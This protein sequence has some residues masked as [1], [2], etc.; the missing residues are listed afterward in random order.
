[1]HSSF[2]TLQR[3]IGCGLLALGMVAGAG[4]AQ[5][6]DFPSRSVRLVIPGPA[7]GATDTMARLLANGLSEKWGQSVVVE[8]K[9]GGTGLVSLR[10]TMGA[11]PDGHVLSM[12]IS[13]FMP[14]N[15]LTHGSQYEALTASTPIAFLSEYPLFL[16]TKAERPYSNWKELDAYAKQHSNRASYGVSGVAGTPHLLGERIKQRTGIDLQPVPYKGDAPMLTAVI[17]DQVDFA[18]PIAA[19]AMPMVKAGRVKPLAVTSAERAAFAPDVPTLRE[20]GLEL[21]S[22]P[23]AMIAG[24]AGMKADL[25]ARIN[26][27]VHDVIAS[28]AM[29]DYY[30]ANGVVSKKMTP[31]ELAAYVTSENDVA[32]KIIREANIEVK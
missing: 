24:P 13:G 18:M 28:K 26:Q 6:Q 21:V 29:R 30:E 17:G 3:A 7:G 10:E 9:P 19:S 4:M 20:Q 27:D 5:A 22:A 32:L 8:N 11:D 31:Q 25:V 12:M 2:K 15:A 1:M 16:V 14:I 23:W